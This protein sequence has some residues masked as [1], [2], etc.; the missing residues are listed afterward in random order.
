M[1]KMTCPYLVVYFITCSIREYRLSRFKQLRG[2]LS[3]YM[4]NRMAVN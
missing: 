3:M 4:T 2:K 1:E